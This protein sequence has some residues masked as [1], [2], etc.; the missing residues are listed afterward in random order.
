MFW[1]RNAVSRPRQACEFAAALADRRGANVLQQA[2][3]AERETFAVGVVSVVAEDELGAAAADIENQQV[4]G[5][6][7]AVGRDAEV[8]PLRLLFAS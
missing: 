3:A 1:L 4:L 7:L 6:Q 2:H 8:N 5:V